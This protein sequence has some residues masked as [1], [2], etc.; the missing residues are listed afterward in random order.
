MRLATI[1]TAIA[2]LA[3]GTGIIAYFGFGHIVQA[4]LS[5]GWGGFAAVCGFHLVLF[6]LLGLAWRVIVPAPAAGVWTFIWGRLIRD[7]GSEVL[8]LSQ[9]GGFVMG[10][11]AAALT[12]LAAP[13]AFASTVVDVTLEVMAQIAYIAL[14]IALLARQAP[15]SDAVVPLGIG[16]AVAIAATIGFVIVQRRGFAWLETLA[17]RSASR[18]LPSALAHGASV[19]SA[20]HAIYGYPRGLALGILLHLVGWIANGVEAYIALRF[21]GVPIGI[22]AV[23]AIES[24]LYAARS[25]AFAVPNAVGVQ[26]G[27]YVVL[28]GLFGLGPEIV[29][30]LS[31]LKRARDLIIGIPALLAWQALEGGQLWQ[32]RAVRSEAR[33]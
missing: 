25:A 5:V 22:G 13:V 27:A 28:G 31:L 6:G 33:D 3:L 1:V 17:K 11:R 23:L 19:Q 10:A 24:L 18:M 9:L 8:P 7:S 26:E 2:G 21:M 15:Q 30:A 32:R 20:I 12:G 14:G 4:L 29:L 16:L